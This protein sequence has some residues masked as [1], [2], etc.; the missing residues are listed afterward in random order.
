[1]TD[2]ESFYQQKVREAK[3]SAAYFKSQGIEVDYRDLL[4]AK[5]ILYEY[6]RLSAEEAAEDA[7][8]DGDPSQWTY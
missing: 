3:E 8:G 5:D 7:A 1:M 4:D 6:N 2:I